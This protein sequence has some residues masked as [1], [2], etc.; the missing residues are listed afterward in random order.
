MTP[1]NIFKIKRNQYCFD[2]FGMILITQGWFQRKEMVK[3]CISK[4][5]K[6]I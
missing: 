4:N 5:R 1:T 6:V 3:K 2:D